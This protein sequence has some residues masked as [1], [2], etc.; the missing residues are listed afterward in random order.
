MQQ[1]IVRSVSGGAAVGIGCDALGHGSGLPP[2]ETSPPGRACAM[3]NSV[4]ENRA[5]YGSLSCASGQMVRAIQ[6]ISTVAKTCRVKVVTIRFY[7]REGIVPR[8]NRSEIGRRLLRRCGDRTSPLRQALPAGPRGQGRLVARHILDQT[9]SGCACHWRRRGRRGCR[10]HAVQDHRESF[11]SGSLPVPVHLTVH[12]RDLANAK[13]LRCGTFNLKRFRL[14]PV[15]S[16][17]CTVT[18]SGQCSFP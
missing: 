11:G 3:E 17:L 6:S 13:E 2:R 1:D 18:E 5:C 12:A 10:R 16:R 8:P 7:E 14:G 15:G 4:G 9:S